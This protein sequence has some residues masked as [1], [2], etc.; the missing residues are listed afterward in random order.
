MPRQGIM[1]AQPMD[2]KNFQFNLKMA[3]GHLL[4]QPKL[5]GVRCWVSWEDG[6]PILWSSEGHM[7]QLPHVA[8]A[9]K[10]F[11][12]LTGCAYNFDGEIYKHGLPFEEIVSMAKNVKRADRYDLEYHIFDYKSSGIQ[13]NRT[14]NLSCLFHTWTIYSDEQ[15]RWIIKAVPTYTCRADNFDNLLAGFMESGYE[16]IIV[17]NPLASY[18]E[19]RVK[20]MLKWKP[21]KQD[22]Y[23]IVEVVEAIDAEGYPK[24]YCGALLCEDE[25]GNVFSVG[26]GTGIDRTQMIDIWKRRNLLVGQYATVV[27][28]CLTT[29]KVPRFG[30]FISIHKEREENA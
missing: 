29:K 6:E 20:T 22:E 19:K 21:G 7:Y 4:A 15:L 8:L 17:R 16:G 26:T 27:Y 23:K 9:L 10:S 25:S 5:D 11:K 2:D 13:L 18:V 28:Q 24:G 14:K 3:K 12:E 1:L 30:K